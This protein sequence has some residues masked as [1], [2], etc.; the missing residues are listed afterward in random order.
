L[1]VPQ[2]INRAL[3]EFIAKHQ[4][5]TTPEPPTETVQDRQRRERIEELSHKL[6]LPQATIRKH[7]MELSELQIAQK[8]NIHQDALPGFRKYIKRTIKNE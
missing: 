8:Y 1:S 6:N 4:V 2:I 7:I 3:N 5:P